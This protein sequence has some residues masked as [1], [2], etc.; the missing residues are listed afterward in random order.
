MSMF[1]VPTKNTQTSAPSTAL[2]TITCGRCFAL[3]HSL[4]PTFNEVAPLFSCFLLLSCI[5]V[6]WKHSAAEC[7]VF[8]AQLWEKRKNP[9]LNQNGILC[10]WIDKSQLAKSKRVNRINS[11]VFSLSIPTILGSKHIYS[12][13]CQADFLAVVAKAADCVVI[14]SSIKRS[15][16]KIIAGFLFKDT[17]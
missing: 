5:G 15:T 4:A 12:C 17:K 7:F 8:R 3:L 2:K 13:P 9:V 16:I 11:Y 6:Q 10:Q 14:W 1:F